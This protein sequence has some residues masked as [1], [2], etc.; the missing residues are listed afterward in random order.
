MKITRKHRSLL[1]PLSFAMLV[2]SGCAGKKGID[3]TPP[4]VWVS[5]RPISSSHYIGIGSAAKTMVA[6]EAMQTAKERA[7]ADLAAEISVRVQSTSLLESAESNGSVSQHFSSSISSRA[8]E[9]ISG[10]EVVDA[11]ED[12]DRVHVYYRLNK[13]RHAAQREAR[14][15]EAMQ[16]AKLEYSTGRKALEEGNILRALG[17]WSHGIMVLE[18]F[19]NEVNRTEVD[20]QEVNLESH[21]IGSMRQTLQ[22]IELVPIVQT[23]RLNAEGRFRFPLGMEASINGQIITGV[24]IAY[25]YHNGTYRKSGTEFTDDNGQVVALISGVAPQRPDPDFTAVMDVDRLWK[26]AEV[27]PTVIALCGD[28]VTREIHIPIEVEMP[29]IYVGA[30]VASALDASQM[31]GPIEAMRRVLIREGF[32]L[33]ENEAEAQF[34]LAFRLRSELRTPAGGGLGDFH[35]AY[36]EGII[37]ARDANGALV[38]ETRV[39]RTKGVQLNSDAALRLALSNAAES[40]EKSLGKKVADTL[41]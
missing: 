39:E 30:D 16:S 20:G 5:Q 38:N 27:D 28:P 3:Q 21:L 29:R 33:V 23:V 10:F 25:A 11:W 9:R 31:A 1:I 22:D 37:A 18:E 19:W 35:T 40:I 15:Q 17:H 34:N 13:T 26:Q 36:V 32:E 7:A 41:H 4:P 24:P 12:N 2:F 6:N 14:R 8:D